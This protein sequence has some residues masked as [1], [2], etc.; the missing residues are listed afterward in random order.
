MRRRLCTDA[1]AGACTQG[2][3][4]RRMPLN[5]AGVQ[6]LPTA[7]P[8]LR[9]HGIKASAVACSVQML[10]S[11]PAILAM[12]LAD[13][14]ALLLYN[15]A[16][17]SVMGRLGSLFRCGSGR[18]QHSPP[19]ASCGAGAPQHVRPPALLA[20]VGLVARRL[21]HLL[22]S[23]RQAATPLLQPLPPPPN[24]HTHTHTRQNAPLPSFSRR[25]VLETIRTLLVWLGAL[26]LFYWPF[27]AGKL[28]EPWSY[29]SWLQA[30]G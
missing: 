6:A 11:S 8:H 15:V 5:A 28:G 2:L 12:L 26:L 4:G 24:T 3:G 16:G 18:W 7:A 23:S 10:A 14:A 22:A 1:G 19:W 21:S 27:T 29:Y 13:M 25:T 30:A 20:C 17:M 9:Q